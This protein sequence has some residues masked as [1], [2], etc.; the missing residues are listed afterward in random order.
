MRV[1][2][3]SRTSHTCSLAAVVTLTVSGLLTTACSPAEA[4][5]HN[6]LRTPTEISVQGLAQTSDAGMP[7]QWVEITSEMAYA[8]PADIKP[9][10]GKVELKS[11][12]APAGDT[13]GMG[14]PVEWRVV[15]T[16]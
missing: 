7:C 9:A 10:A 4:E 6:A 3:R 8:I 1:Q 2:F 15:P 12:G 13:T 11:C 14:G 5:G 16:S